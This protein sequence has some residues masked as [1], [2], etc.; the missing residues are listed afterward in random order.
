M[1]QAMMEAIMLVQTMIQM[2]GDGGVCDKKN[3]I[4][5]MKQPKQL[6]GT[7]PHMKYTWPLFCYCID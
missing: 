7:P 1:M 3:N 4:E 2:M 5:M 6:H